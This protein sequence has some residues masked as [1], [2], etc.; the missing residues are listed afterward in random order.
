[1]G[2]RPSKD[3]KYVELVRKLREFL[4]NEI[5]RLLNRI[6]VIV[7][8][9]LDLRSPDLTRRMNRLITNLG[10]RYIN[11]K[12]ERLKEL[13]GIEII[14]SQ[15]CSSCGYIDKRNRKDTQKINAQV[16]GARNI[17]KRSF[18]HTPKKRDTKGVIVLPVQTPSV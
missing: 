11:K 17:L 7:I 8:E 12:I 14:F 2:R 6:V 1:M 4:K 9:R 3:G 5:N 18:L 16:N 10:R 15:E 13:Y